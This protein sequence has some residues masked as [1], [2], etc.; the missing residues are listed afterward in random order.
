MT[1]PAIKDGFIYGVCNAGE[2]R[3]VN[4]ATGERVWET[5]AA[6]DGKH[7]F[8]AH[9]FVIEHENRFL[10]FNDHGDL[11]IAN[12]SPKGYEEISRAK[13]IEPTIVKRGRLAAWAYPAFANKCIY[14]RNDKEIVCLSLAA[15]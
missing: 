14:V 8:L 13:I 12:L 9:A 15:T 7:A 5:Y 2:L 1:T 11:I 3:C 6:T 4:A 10:I